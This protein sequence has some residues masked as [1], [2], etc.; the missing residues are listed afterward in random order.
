[1]T[2]GTGP[3]AALDQ[4]LAFRIAFVAGLA[5]AVVGWV[6]VA[7]IWYPPRW[8]SVDW[9]FGSVSGTFDAL[10]LSTIGLTLMAMSAVARGRTVAAR[11]LAALMLFLAVA[12]VVFVVVLL[13]DV[14]VVLRALQEQVR[15][16]MKRSVTKT[17]AIAASYLVL[18]TVTGVWLI[19]RARPQRGGVR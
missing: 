13:L 1:V 15:P 4:E 18:Y 7:F 19:R 10:P 9:E 11:V 14:P 8:A 3:V 5:L 12:M 16:V 17:L 2:G 6:D